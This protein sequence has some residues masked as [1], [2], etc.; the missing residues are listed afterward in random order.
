MNGEKIKTGNLIT[1]NTMVENNRT[2]DHLN[3]LNTVG[4]TT[5]YSYA[6]VGLRKTCQT[7][8]LGFLKNLL[9]SRLG[10][11]VLII[12]NP[13]KSF[14]WE[15]LEPVTFTNWYGSE[16]NTYYY[17]CTHIRTVSVTT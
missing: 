17:D 9:L 6:F 13:L 5:Y 4:T 14:Y 8:S 3:A 2:M 10:Y 15:D 7:C 16:P 11:G 12:K 1:I